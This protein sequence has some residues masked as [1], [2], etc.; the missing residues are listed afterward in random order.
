MIRVALL[1]LLLLPMIVS[2]DCSGGNNC[3]CTQ[4]NL[5]G[6]SYFCGNSESDVGTCYS[7]DASCVAE[8]SSNCYETSGCGLPIVCSN[9]QASSCQSAGLNC[10]L[11][12]TGTPFCTQGSV[13]CNYETMVC[14]SGTV[15]DPVSGDC[16]TPNTNTT[17]C[18]ACQFAMKVLY[19]YGNSYCDKYCDL[20]PYP[21]NGM[22]IV[23]E[24]LGINF[25][26]DILEWLESGFTPLA[27]C[28]MMPLGICSGGA[29]CACGY[30]VPQFYGQW[31]LSLPNHCPSGGSG[32][33][34]DSHEAQGLRVTG[35]ML[36]RAAVTNLSSNQSAKVIPLENHSAS[37]AEYEKRVAAFVTAMTV[38][39]QK[40][41]AAG[42]EAEAATIEKHVSRAEQQLLRPMH[43]RELCFNGMCNASYVGCC[44]TCAP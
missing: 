23:L 35:N 44:L 2:A 34:A 24:K 10:C 27:V 1:L 41:R 14:S 19:E 33:D 43:E 42:R 16:I 36:K 6:Y 18:E 4:C 26:T 8:C 30:C 21:F 29:T 37:A 11:D 5:A 12:S 40:Y 20:L 32:S 3:T 7:L 15:C 13:C 38:T 17:A 25:C 39:A 28:E 22:C 31:C 9:A